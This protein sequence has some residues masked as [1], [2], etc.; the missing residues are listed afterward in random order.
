MPTARLS[1]LLSAVS[2]CTSQ[3]SPFHPNPARR[4]Q[5]NLLPSPGGSLRHPINA[6]GLVSV[7]LLPITGAHFREWLFPITR[8]FKTASS[9]VGG[10][11]SVH[12]EPLAK[13]PSSQS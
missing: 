8:S 9:S 1:F 12:E 4:L 10:L 3:G 13:Y 7:R 11:S 6:G 5:I 2:A